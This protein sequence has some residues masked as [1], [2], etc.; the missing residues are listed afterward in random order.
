MPVGDGVVGGVA[1]GDIDGVETD[2]PEGD[3]VVEGVDDGDID[4]VE[5][6]VPEGDGMAEGVADGDAAALP[7]TLAVAD[8]VTVLLSVAGSIPDVEG[9]GETVDEGE[10]TQ[11]RS[12]ASPPSPAP[13]LGELKVAPLDVAI[14]EFT[15][16]EPPPPPEYDELEPCEPPPPPQ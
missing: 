9:D 7:I 16:D 13:A 8:G 14:A 1:D 5:T 12:V 15:Y 10:I 3:G 6:D 11:A 2:V 4:G